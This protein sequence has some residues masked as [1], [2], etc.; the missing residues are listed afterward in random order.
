MLFLPRLFTSLPF[1]GL[2]LAA[3][4]VGL[5]P[6]ENLPGVI[7]TRVLYHNP[8]VYAAWPAMVRAGNGDVLVTFIRTEQHM[9]PNGAVSLMR[10]TDNGTSWSEP[11]DVVD[12][13]IDDRECGLTVAPDGSLLL[14]V[15]SVH[16]KA[17]TYEQL[18]PEAY[19]REW[20]ERWAAEVSTPDYLAAADLDGSHVY[21]STDHGHTWQRRGRGPDSIHGGITLRDGSLLVAGYREELDA[22]RLYRAA[23]PGAPWETVAIIASPSPELRFGEPHVA[24]LPSGRIVVMMRATA[25]AYDDTRA[26]LFLW[27]VYS[28]DGGTTWTDPVPTPM[29]GFPPHLTVLNDGRLL[30]TYGRRRAPYGQRAMISA[31][32]ITWNPA[33][34]IVLRQDAPNHDLGYPASLEITPGRI[35]TV[36]YQKPAWDPADKHRHTTAIS[37]TT[38]M[39]PE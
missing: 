8:A 37:A 28:D 6:A 14:H 26:D 34:E 2:S 35:L 15:R 38:W 31:D 11:V 22:A 23:S 12:T 9:S 16:W 29:L 36:Y 30:C 20:L 32:G 25:R 5:L 1:R 17:A 39:L 4:G 24:Q 33:S 7:D 18:G 3:F 13:P 21:Q 19:R 10:S 27:Q